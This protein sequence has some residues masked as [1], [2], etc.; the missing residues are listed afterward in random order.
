MKEKLK[1]Q[2]RLKYTLNEEDDASH[3]RSLAEKQMDEASAEYEQD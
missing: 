2:P 1:L 3:D